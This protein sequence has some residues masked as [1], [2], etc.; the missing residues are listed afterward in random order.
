MGL[1]SVEIVVDIENAFGIQI[2]GREAEKIITVGDFHNVVWEHVKD[3]KSIKCKSQGL[4]YKLR[5]LLSDELQIR[6]QAITPETFLSDIIPIDNRRK[7]WSG[8]ASKIEYRL[9]ELVLTEPYAIFVIITGATLIFGSLAGSIILIHFFY[10]TRWLYFIP[11]AG[12][13]ISILI[14]KS[15]DPKRIDFE[16]ENFRELVNK[17]SIINYAKLGV[18]DGFVRKEVEMIITNVIADKAGLEWN[19][20]TP[21]KRICDDLGIN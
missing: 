9:P 20:V 10:F 5:V 14:S 12:I 3:R 17:I 21:E 18:E 13:L 15:L 2:P 8:F 1:D 19:E 6:K 16:Q 7:L 11:F 4:F